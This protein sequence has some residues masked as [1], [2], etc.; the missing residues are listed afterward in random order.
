MSSNEPVLYCHVC[1]EKA[2]QIDDEI[3][4]DQAFGEAMIIL[5]N[6]S[7][8]IDKIRAFLDKHEHC[9]PERNGIVCNTE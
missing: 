2:L 9:S 6:G 8:D 7:I 3:K 5:W 1:R 4:F